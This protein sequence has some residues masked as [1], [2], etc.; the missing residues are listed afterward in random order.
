MEQEVLNLFSDRFRRIWIQRSKYRIC[1]T[2][3]PHGLNNPYRIIT[4][5]TIYHGFGQDT[6]IED[7][8]NL[9]NTKA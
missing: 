4:T 1:V 6:N 8:I 3:F 7:V 9:I 5:D 2:L